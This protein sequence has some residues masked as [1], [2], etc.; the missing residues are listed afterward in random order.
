MFCHEVLGKLDSEWYVPACPF[1]CAFQILD[2]LGHQHDTCQIDNIVYADT[3]LKALDVASSMI[4]VVVPSEN[5]VG[6][7]VGIS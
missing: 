4:S 5:V 1:S 7:C 2:L 3:I 6:D